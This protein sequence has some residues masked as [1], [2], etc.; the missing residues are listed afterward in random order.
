M[1]N[2]CLIKKSSQFKI[3]TQFKILSLLLILIF[4]FNILAA[5]NFPQAEFR[6][7]T[8]GQDVTDLQVK[9]YTY[10]NDSLFD[11]VTQ[12]K[13]FVP[14]WKA[15]KQSE[16]AA[17][18]SESDFKSS[19]L[20]NFTEAEAK[21]LS[22]VIFAYGTLYHQ[23]T[24]SYAAFD[25]N[26]YEQA[27]E[28]VKKYLQKTSFIK[29]EERPKIIKDF[30][31]RLSLNTEKENLILNR[32]RK[33]YNPYELNVASSAQD[34]YFLL[35]EETAVFLKK[36]KNLCLESNSYVNIAIGSL[37]F[38][39]QSLRLQAVSDSGRDN[40]LNKDEKT[41]KSDIAS[42]V[43][44]YLPSVNINFLELKDVDDQ[45]LVYNPQDKYGSSA[46]FAEEN[47]FSYIDEQKTVLAGQKSGQKQE[48]SA[49]AA[50]KR[51]YT[52]AR[53]YDV[54]TKL[55]TGAI[56]KGFSVQQMADFIK[57]YLGIHNDILI[58]AGGNVYAIGQKL[59][60]SGKYSPWAVAVAYPSSFGTEIPSEFQET[61][62]NNIELLQDL[63]ALEKKAGLKEGS[64][65]SAMIEDKMKARGVSKIDFIQNK[66][67]VSSGDYERYFM[68]NNK[69]YHHILGKSGYPV[70]YYR[71][72]S[73]IT[74]NS[75]RG[76]AFST[77]IFNM[78]LVEALSFANREKLKLF[79]VFEG[80]KYLEFEP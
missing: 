58:S 46:N 20:L 44:E 78:P 43:K 35:P 18:N 68:L 1:K 28:K 22:E 27:Y 39:W 16:S 64:L 33:V 24:S 79:L 38:Y 76:D 69:L 31:R 23:L 71:Q 74:E 2:F 40:I 19:P 6:N 62:Q 9:D 8:S 14:L 73:I 63:R 57:Y 54:K 10:L 75:T 61:F 5:C 26:K 53:I 11:T 77:A 34:E 59:N 30:E 49:A 42:I 56:A 47:Y 50:S 4:M 60:R 41:L 36:A 12:I 51:V 70:Y 13:I 80:G 7:S 25:K 37:S 48:D 45:G 17:T 32:Y 21:E 65:K 3:L 66:S 15:S 52:L 67:Y 72:V 55:D 29:E